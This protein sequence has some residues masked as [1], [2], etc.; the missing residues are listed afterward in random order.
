MAKPAKLKLLLGATFCVVLTVLA[1]RG[2]DSRPEP[3]ST[4]SQIAPAP[5][6]LTPEQLEAENAAR[7]AKIEAQRAKQEADRISRIWRRDESTDDMTGKQ[8]VSVW[9]RSTYSFPLDFPHRGMH[10]GYLTVRRHP[11]YGTDV[12]ISV[13]EGQ[14][15]CDYGDC[16]VLVRFDDKK[17]SSY[18]VTKPSDHSSKTWFLNDTSRFLKSLAR[19]SHMTVELRFYRQGNRTLKFETTGF[20]RP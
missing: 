19:S 18:A 8:E 13:D 16:K 6:V 9:T 1:L 20:K 3:D 7:Q 12:M 11:R 4:A 10:Y 5:L 14:M 2:V 15:I 17:A